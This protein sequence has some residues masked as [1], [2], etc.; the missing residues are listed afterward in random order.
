MM[1][2]LFT[3]FDSIVDFIREIPG[4]PDYHADRNG[5]IYSTKR[6][7]R[8]LSPVIHRSG[9]ATVYLHIDGRPHTRYVHHLVAAAFVGPRPDG[10]L[11]CHTPDPAKSNNRADNLAYQTRLK[12]A[13]DSRR[14]G[15]I[16]QA[17][18]KLVADDV[19]EIRRLAGTISNTEIARRYGIGLDHVR[20]IIARDR[21]AH[22]E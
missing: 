20:L 19:R 10:L 18:R 7:L 21:W 11:V 14:D 22:V 15:T 12:N 4:C 3:S 16:Q 5:N 8:L 2:D 9:Y 13:E 17:R 6:G 1:H